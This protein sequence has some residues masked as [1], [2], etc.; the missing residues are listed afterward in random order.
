MQVLLFVSCNITVNLYLTPASIEKALISR[1]PILK[2][3]RIESLASM[4]NYSTDQVSTLM[5]HFL[6]HHLFLLVASSCALTPFDPMLGVLLV[7]L[8][9]QNQK[10]F[11]SRIF[12]IPHY[13]LPA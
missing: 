7:K 13:L 5:Q 6:E 9:G 12:L 3:F 4:Y 1:R 11:R 2:P 10:I 8:G